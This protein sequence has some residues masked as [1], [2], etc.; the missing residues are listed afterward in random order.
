[1]EHPIMPMVR[2][3]VGFEPHPRTR[4]P[5]FAFFL[6]SEKKEG[7]PLNEAVLVSDKAQGDYYCRRI[8]KLARVLFN[9][10]PSLCHNIDKL[11]GP[12]PEISS[13]M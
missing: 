1:M 2:K 10:S 9:V 4:K 13:S 8:V 6:C 12:K 3:A 7:R 5:D 11:P